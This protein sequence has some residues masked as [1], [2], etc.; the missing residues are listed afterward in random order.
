MQNFRYQIKLK[1]NEYYHRR[2]RYVNRINF[3]IKKG[4]V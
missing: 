1:K 3:K 4:K 2:L